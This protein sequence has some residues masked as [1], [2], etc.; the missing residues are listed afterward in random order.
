MVPVKNL[1]TR[2][3]QI[4]TVEPVWEFGSF[5]EISQLRIV[6]PGVVSFSLDS[7]RIGLAVALQALGALEDVVYPF[8]KIVK[9]KKSVLLPYGLLDVFKSGGSQ[10]L[11]DLNVPDPDQVGDPF[12]QGGDVV[13]DLN[14]FLVPKSLPS[15]GIGRE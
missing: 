2:L 7:G 3:L 6:P 4:D 15:H 8:F 5:H 14:L 1:I 10:D 9:D 11:D 13:S 12:G